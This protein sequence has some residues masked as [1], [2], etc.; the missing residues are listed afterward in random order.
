[1]RKLWRNHE[2]IMK[3]TMSV[4]ALDARAGEFYAKEINEL[5][6]EYVEIASYNVSDGSAVGTLPKADLFVISTDAYGSAEEVAS[7]VPIDS[8]TMGI[9]VSYRWS[10]LQ[11]LSMIPKGTRAL[12]VNMTDTMARE[13]IAQLQQLGVNHIRFIPF[14]PGA[15][16]EEPVDMAVTPEE[17]RYVPQSVKKVLNIGHRS[18]TSGMMIEIALRMGLEELLETKK[19]QN[20]F[21]AMATNN[22]SFN[23][24]YARS[25]RLESQFHILME[26]LDEGLVGVNEKGE[27]FACN[28][29]ACQIA[30]IV[31]N[32]VIGRC[33]EKVF[34]YIPFYSA[35]KDKKEITPK[36]I[37][38][39]GVNVSIEVIPVLRQKKCIGAFATLQEFSELE[40]KQ[41]ELRSQLLKKGYCAKYTFND[42]IGES[43][44]I[45]QTKGI[46]KRMAATESPVLIVGE[47]GTGKEL[48]AHAVHC[49]SKRNKGPFIAI[50][51][52]AMP[53]NLLE[54]ELFGYEEGAF[55]GAKKGGRPG[56]FEFAH[57]G[58][59]FLDEV[60]GMSQAMQV[61]LLRVLQEG[62]VMRVGGSRIVSVDVRI[63]AATNESLEQKVEEGSFRK[64]LYYR[65][66]TLTV[67]VPLLQE[68]GEDVFLL[69][70]HFKE[71]LQGDFK[72]S[73]EVKDFLRQYS[74]PGNIRELHNTVEYFVYTRKQVIDMDDLPPTIFHDRTSRPVN[75]E[76]KERMQEVVSPFWF[77]LE[78][79]YM[80][81]ERNEFIGRDKL[82]LKAKKQYLLLSQKE[83][84]DILK[85][86]EKKGF[87]KIGKGRG[88]S[89]ITLEGKEYWQSRDIMCR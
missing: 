39:G 18:C 74:W 23:Q 40:S 11:N 34:P 80:A 86:M 67:V 65:L 87:V 14:Y 77:V 15:V 57:G 6:G 53:E 32:L 76:K 2:G 46:L 36:V 3:K 55:T 88:G 33:G 73:E 84:R 59:L 44:C 31:E 9:E 12:F 71:E 42:V 26:I 69:M 10:T 22:Y 5:F 7:H 16:L 83:I 82:L 38:L 28:K 64:D 13:A 41:N 17:E 62:E 35:L 21:Q 79:L 60:E 1:M 89:R 30:K 85:D 72:L 29:K 81:A 45:C 70:E 19:F 56:L 24:I 37:K 4:V 48:L 78:Q 51:V 52:A 27:I 8:L 68:R 58:T 43:D 20:Y 75:M 49:A 47:T 25:R 66:N 61:K 63:V 54:S 50:N